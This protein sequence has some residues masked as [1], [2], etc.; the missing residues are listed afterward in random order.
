MSGLFHFC[1]AVFTTFVGA[2]KHPM[3]P[4]YLPPLLLALLLLLLS[5]QRT[6]AQKIGL[7]LSGGGA[8][9]VT[10]IGVIKALEEKGIPI[11]Y[12]T[13]TSSGAFIGALYAAGYSP[14]EM[15]ALISN[16]EFMYWVT[17]RVDDSYIYYFKEQEPNAAWVDVKFNLDSLVLPSLIPTSII[18]PI[19]LD[20]A[21]MEIF[22]TPSAAAQDNFD[23]LM[24]PF[25]CVASD[26][27]ESKAVV[28]NK[29]SLASSVRASM[30]FPFLF[31]PIRIDNKL[32]FDG[33]MYNNFPSD[34]M[35]SDFHPD[36]IIG[37]K[38]AANYG[39]PQAKNIISQIQTMLMTKTDYSL[40]NVPGII[41]SPDLRD[42]SLLDFDQSTYVMDSGYQATMRQMHLIEKMLS[43]RI[44][45]EALKQKRAIFKNKMKPLVIDSFSISGLNKNQQQYLR[46]SLS[47][48]SQTVTSNQ[49]KQE[50]FKVLADS[51][52]ESMYPELHYDSVSERFILDLAVEKGKNITTQIGGNISSSP[53]NEAFFSIHYKVLGKKAYTMF[54]NSY[55]GRF[56]SSALIGAKI[57]VPT[58]Q[59][60]FLQA[61]FSLNQWDYFKTTTFFFEDKTPS[62]LVINDMHLEMDMGIP[63][64]NKAK[65][66]GGLAV[67]SM[68]DEYYQTNNFRRT[69]TTDKTYFDFLTA[70]MFYDKNTLNLK[71]YANRGMRIF[72]ELRY[73]SGYETYFPGSTA[74]NEDRNRYDK[75][76]AWWQFRGLYQNYFAHPG[77]F[78]FGLYGELVYSTQ[79]FF[80]NATSTLLMAP[81][82]NLVP[83]TRTLFLPSY[84]AN[85]FFAVGPQI[86]FHL[87][88]NMDIR[89]EGYI[90]QAFNEL[91]PQEDQSIINGESFAT[92]YL[93][94]ST[95]FI[96]HS[97]IGPVSLSY[98]YF[99][100]TDYQF[101]LIFSIGYTIFN[102]KALD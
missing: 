36:I 97:P 23:S 69:D 34:V 91:I 77:K 95:S 66:Q 27:A 56:Y 46:R 61:V 26:I 73:V 3:K 20:Y 67:A 54:V 86:V 71:E 47:H 29:G 48:R 30:T 15:M 8:K 85:Q 74:S 28:M 43:R 81:A 19:R 33:G 9:G 12:I 75:Y 41:I 49:V 78:S 100:K 32:L 70:H 37:S 50:Y 101:S 79:D 17:G 22:G 24:V 13:G 87:F 83:E 59:P 62:Y 84:R 93:V 53:S 1:K 92:R 82:F 99:K 4:A 6:H 18:S 25:R 5:A 7:V 64:G 89:A 80:H 96:Y 65:F 42:V 76:H 68:R 44:S 40:F 35:V 10:H 45:P 98:N 57:D 38:A 58:K 16:D 94:T 11:D 52:F 60:F 21:L 51:K 72:G 63:L 88:K 55:I 31:S 102:R 39:P 90:F 2:K 14:D